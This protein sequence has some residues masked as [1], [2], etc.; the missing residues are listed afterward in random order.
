ME[1]LCLFVSNALE[2]DLTVI[3]K[4]VIKDEEL[5]VQATHKTNAE[6]GGIRLGKPL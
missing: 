5:W 1:R 2:F 4:S 3:Q 6:C